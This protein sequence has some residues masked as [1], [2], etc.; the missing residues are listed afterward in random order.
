MNVRKIKKLFPAKPT[1]EGAGVRLHRGFGYEEVPLFDPFLL[2]DDF[3][4]SDPQDY[5]PGFPWHP[6]RGIETVTYMI[7]GRVEHE[8]SLGNK[9]VIADGDVQWMTAGSGIIHQEMPQ[10]YR[11]TSKGFQLW[12]NLPR[13]KKMMPP[14][15]R[16]IL[17]KDIPTVERENADVKVIAGNYQGTAGPVADLAVHSVYLDVALRARQTFSCEVPSHHTVF[18]YVFEGSIVIGDD[19]VIHESIVVLTLEG[20]TVSVNTRNEGARFL[21]IG[22]EPLGEPVA[23]RGPIV[24]NTDEELERA[25]EEYRNGTFVRG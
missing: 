9:G 15:Y 18:L 11:G 10:Q 20:S 7:R 8:D 17:S 5:L 24:M 3:G 6:H 19:E 14:R 23:W 16:G 4:S 25:F 2:L 12:I 13:A 22:G 1:L 21:L